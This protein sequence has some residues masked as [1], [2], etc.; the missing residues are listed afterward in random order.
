MGAH[1]RR[2]HTR[3]SVVDTVFFLVF[4]QVM[5]VW[6]VFSPLSCS[7]APRAG[8]KGPGNR[9]GPGT[10]GAFG[11]FCCL[12][13]GRV[14]CTWVALSSSFLVPRRMNWVPQWM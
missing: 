14:S 12:L 11:V 8:G 3:W 4:G 5:T 2:R 9:N 10:F 13:L 7:S 1:S 6:L